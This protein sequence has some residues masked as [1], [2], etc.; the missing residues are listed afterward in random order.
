MGSR[1]PTTTSYHAPGRLSSS[2]PHGAG[3]NEHHP[4]GKWREKNGG[5]GEVK[6]KI[7]GKI[8]RWR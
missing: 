8:G 5:F 2:T 1:G 3:T 4:A 7:L 6:G